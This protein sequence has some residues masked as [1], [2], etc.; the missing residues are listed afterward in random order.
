[1]PLLPSAAL[2][3][4]PLLLHPAK[5]ELACLQKLR[6]AMT[7]VPGHPHVIQLLDSHVNTYEP[8]GVS[9]V[10]TITR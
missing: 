8:G 3:L 5:Q 10:Y 9:W 2:L 6:C 1:M 7:Q 4:T